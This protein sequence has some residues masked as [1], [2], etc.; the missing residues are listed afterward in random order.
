MN[1]IEL[2]AK[3]GRKVKLVLK[4]SVLSASFDVSEIQPNDTILVFFTRRL[5]ADNSVKSSQAA[6]PPEGES[7]SGE[8][9]GQL[10]LTN[11][12]ASAPFRR[13]MGDEQSDTAPA[14]G[15][16]EFVDVF[17]YSTDDSVDPLVH[18]AQFDIQRLMELAPDEVAKLLSPGEL[19]G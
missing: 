12:T 5:G 17:R 3:F 6:E 8:S 18:P 14:K 2:E 4:G 10:L 11:I 9:I 15:K 7:G 16:D 1:G 19:S 13:L